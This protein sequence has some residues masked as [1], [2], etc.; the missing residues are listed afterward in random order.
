MPGI[1]QAVARIF[2]KQLANV[3]LGI[4]NNVEKAHE[5]SEVAYLCRHPSVLDA[6][7]PCSSTKDRRRVLGNVN[8]GLSVTGPLNLSGEGSPPI[9]GPPSHLHP[10]QITLLFPVLFHPS[11]LCNQRARNSSS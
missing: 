8:E 3:S 2:K 10:I 4:R 5:D 6:V 1:C 11:F 7:T 9:P